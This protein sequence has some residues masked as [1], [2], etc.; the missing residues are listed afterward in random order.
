MQRCGLC[1]VL[2][3]LLRRAMCVG[4]RRGSSE[5]YYREL[6]DQDTLKI[7]DK[8]SDLS[9][10][11]EEETSLCNQN[12]P[13]ASPRSSPRVSPR[14]S[15]RVSP[16]T[17]PGPSQKISPR[18]SPR[19]SRRMSPKTSPRSTRR[20][21]PRPS[22][23]PFRRTSPPTY[24]RVFRWTSPRI[25]PQST[26]RTSPRTSRRA[27]RLSQS[28]SQQ[29][30]EKAPD[31]N[32]K[33]KNISAGR[34]LTMHKRRKKRLITRSLYI[35]KA[36]LDD[37][38]IGQVQCILNNSYKWKFNAFTLENVSGGRCLPVLCVHLFQMYGLLAHFNLD[39]AKAWK[40]FSLIEEGY[41]STNPYHNSIHAADVT[42]AMH[43]FLQQKRIRDHL[44]PLEIMGSLLAAIAHDL[45][46][47][48]V[49]QP[50]LIATS[51]HLAALYKNTSV[52][53]NHHW[54]SAM[55][56][57]IES[58]LLDQLPSS[59]G[60]RA[61]L[62]KQISSLI[63]A[64]DITRQQE[65][66]NHFKRHLDMN[67]LDMRK[68][69][70]R[71][72]VLQIALK[73]ADI[74]NPCRPWEI[75]RKWSLKV[76][77]EFFRQ[78]DYE[79]KL[80]LPV[81]ALC[82]RHTTS[83]PK[84]QTGFFKFVVTPLIS[85]WHR[86][87]Q[88]ELSS[89]ML[90]NL[91]YNQKK[92]ETL[93]LEEQAQETRTEISDADAADDDLD[94]SSDT[95]MSDSSELLLPP[96][97]CSLN[98][99]RQNTFKDQ[100]RRFS[101]PLNVFQDSKFRNR[102]R[103]KSR[104]SSL[105]EPR[106]RCSRSPAPSEPSLHSQLSVRGHCEPSQEPTERVLSSEKLLPDSSIASITTPVQATRLNT[107]LKEGGSWKL[108]RQQTFPPIESTSREYSLASRPI[109]TSNEDS[110]FLNRVRPDFLQFDQGPSQRDSKGHQLVVRESK[111]EDSSESSAEALEPPRLQKE[112]SEPQ[113]PSKKESATVGSQLRDNLASMPLPPLESDPLLQRRRKSMP[114]DVF[115][116][117]PKERK[118]REVP[119]AF[120]QYMHRTFSEKESWT[121]RRGSAPLPVAPSELRGL[122]S[123]GSPRHSV[124][125][126]RRKPNPIVSCQ[127]WLAKATVSIQE[128]RL[129]KFPRRSSL[130]VEVMT[131]ISS[132]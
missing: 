118:T 28:D 19:P 119:A 22:T 58:G 101:V 21:S 132:H 123:L 100:L 127:Q 72:L 94:S 51:N 81:T 31:S 91:T 55:S 83:I 75:S 66:L 14:T 98:P 102:E 7:E 128:R 9:D 76:C 99:I 37:L 20:T 43:C 126:G 82:D 80:N 42:Q 107:V 121:R 12:S 95:N 108:V 97:R 122:A 59:L 8:S 130:P 69:E 41:H 24:S 120:P 111:T 84:I 18:T 93:V 38:S 52:L 34:F 117:T 90:N 57:L 16:R 64:T 79:R 13:R 124:N 4:S 77:E 47:P 23:R 106:P 53:E 25:S 113:K 10:E 60:L 67:T 116:F 30:E 87:L 89:Q 63:L 39:A 35:E 29:D 61:A 86:F 73:C 129:Q 109:C 70:H 103:E 92:W 125:G 54:R 15:P 114:A 74:S 65:Y 131:G 45:D 78:G 17:S 104:A 46:H 48:G 40:L 50:F 49:N 88:N 33:F 6:G 26:P 105:A 5:S 11:A 110:I 27:S 112:N 32:N 71:H 3:G 44:T 68:S 85:E 1:S 96:R 115:P 36:L 2:S 56:C 62:E